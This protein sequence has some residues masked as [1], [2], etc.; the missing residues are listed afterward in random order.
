MKIGYRQ[1][2]KDFGRK[3]LPEARSQPTAAAATG[4]RSQRYKT[5]SGALG[6]SR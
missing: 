1:L 3:K 5:Q 4:K 6:G 2:E